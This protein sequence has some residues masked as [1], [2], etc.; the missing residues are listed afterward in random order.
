MHRLFSYGTLRLPDVQVSL[1]GRVVPTID[2]VLGGYRLEWLGITDAEVITTSGADRHPILRPGTGDDFV[3]GA[4]LELSDD[5]LAAA[6][7][8]EVDDYRRVAATL[9]SGVDAWVYVGDVAEEAD[10]SRPA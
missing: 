10:A 2:D 3:E 7:A 1:F 8:Y 5:E 9:V 4:Y 6:D